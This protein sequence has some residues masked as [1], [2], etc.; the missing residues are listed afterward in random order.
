MLQVVTVRR[1]LGDAFNVGVDDLLV[2]LDGEDQGDVHGDALGQGGGDRRQTL[3]GGRD[4]DHGVRTVDLGP[5][6][7]GLLLGGFGFVGQTRIHLDG[8]AAID[9]VGLFRDLAEN[10][11]GVAHV[12]GGELTHCGLDIDLAQ[13]LQLRIVRA[14]LVQSLLEDG[15]VG[16]HADNVLVGDEVLQRTGLDTGTGQVV[17]PNRDTG[18]GGALRCFSHCFSP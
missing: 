16:G 11:G 13:F 4:L 18:I 12:G 3:E 17:Q 8:D 5:K 7:L 14:D 2:T 9:E 6:F 10:V 1:G 15:R